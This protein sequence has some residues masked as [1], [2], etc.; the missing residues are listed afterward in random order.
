[1]QNNNN[2]ND[3]NYNNNDNNNK[4]VLESFG[5]LG[6]KC[7]YTW[8]YSLRGNVGKDFVDGID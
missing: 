3:N 8:F 2:N 7:R 5:V 6:D 1:M 4:V